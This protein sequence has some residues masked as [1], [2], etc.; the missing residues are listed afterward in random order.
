MSAGHTSTAAAPLRDRCAGCNRQS[1]EAG[2]N[3]PAKAQA[4]PNAH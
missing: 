3:K 2:E 4:A 1:Q